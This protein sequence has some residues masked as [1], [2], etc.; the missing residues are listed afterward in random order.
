ML[1]SNAR[2]NTYVHVVDINLHVLHIGQ[3]Y[4]HARFYNTCPCLSTGQWIVRGRR[5]EHGRGVHCTGLE[6]AS[7]A[8]E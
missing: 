3:F 5:G 2:S 8:G 4:W 7:T 1:H 6:E